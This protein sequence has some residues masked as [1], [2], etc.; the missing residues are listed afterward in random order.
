[1]RFTTFILEEN[2]KNQIHRAPLLLIMFCQWLNYTRVAIPSCCV[3]AAVVFFLDF[4]LVLV[5]FYLLNSDSGGLKRKYNQVSRSMFFFS[6]SSY[7]YCISFSSSAATPTHTAVQ[8]VS[9]K[10][11][12]NSAPPPLSENLYFILFY[13][14]F[15][16]ALDFFVDSPHFLAR[17]FIAFSSSLTQ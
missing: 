17:I 10:F 9:A 11:P 13:C 1:M 2:S 15:P 5:Y 4:S 12:S 7:F 3:T 14:Q 8:N 16:I 6:S